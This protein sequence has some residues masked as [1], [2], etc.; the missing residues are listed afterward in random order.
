[1]RQEFLYTAKVEPKQAEAGFK[2]IELK[3]HGF[4]Q[5]AWAKVEHDSLY[6][7]IKSDWCCEHGVF[8]WSIAI[9]ANTTATIS[10]PAQNKGVVMESGRPA[11]TS[12]GVKF[13]RFEGGRAV[14]EV[15]SG[16][17]MFR[18]QL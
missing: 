1:M 5:L 11:E 16:N 14:Y 4:T 2:R 7:P 8:K 18:S 10:V 13:L 12:P 6:G 15:K 17:F 3:P 9:P